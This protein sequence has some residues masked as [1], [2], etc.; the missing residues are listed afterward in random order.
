MT[1]PWAR[2]L[3]G[4]VCAVVGVVLT[5]RPFTSLA[6]LVL[7]V[8]GA[9]FVTGVSEIVAARNAEKPAVAIVVGLGWI[10]AGVLVVAWPGHAIHAVAIVVEISMFL[11]GLTRVLGAVR[12]GVD[13]RVV[14]ALTGAASLI[15]GVLAL[16]WPDITVL[17]IALLVGRA[18]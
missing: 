18:R 2:Q 14:A 10:A 12:G 16:S 4:V 1:R 9:F 13:D 17:V 3:L 5:L 6:A 7:F 11:G 15:F 8:A